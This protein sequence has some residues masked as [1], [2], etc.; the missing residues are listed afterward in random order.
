MVWASLILVTIAVARLTHF[1]TTDR[2]A[3]PFRRAVV[4]KF[5]EDSSTAYFVHCS[6]C[7]SFWISL[8]G[9]PAWA[10][11]MLPLSQWWL[12]APAALSM[13]YVAGILS[14]IEER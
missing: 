6:W 2:V 13:S 14:Q 5:G 10:F 9:G 11:S 1:V 7:T 8:I 4:N 12:A 3:L